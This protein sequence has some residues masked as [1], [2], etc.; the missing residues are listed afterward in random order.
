MEVC[1]LDQNTLTRKTC[2]KVFDS[3]LF[4]YTKFTVLTWNSTITTLASKP[5]SE[6][7][8]I[9]LHCSGQKHKDLKPISDNTTTAVLLLSHFI[10][11]PE[12]CLN[13]I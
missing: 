1:I 8:Y 7:C 9:R 6:G 5:I 12:T 2:P 4:F 10:L 13:F 11:Y 3:F